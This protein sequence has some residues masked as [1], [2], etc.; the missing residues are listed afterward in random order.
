MAE[1]QPKTGKNTIKLVLTYIDPCGILQAHPDA[2]RKTF[3]A[4]RMRV[5]LSLLNRKAIPEQRKP[6][7]LDGVF[8]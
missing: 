8:L 6:R 2:Q 1:I 3:C 5:T 7:L 4:Y